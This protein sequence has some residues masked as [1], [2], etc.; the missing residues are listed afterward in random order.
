MQSERLHLR[1][2][3]RQFQQLNIITDKEN[4]FRLTLDAETPIQI[5]MLPG[6][7]NVKSLATHLQ[8]AGLD[9]RPILYPTVP[10]GGE[11]LRIVFHAF[12]TMDE[13]KRLAGL[14]EGYHLSPHNR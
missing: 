7:S 3:I 6:N 5:L 11:R 14:L 1:E 12:N 13:V 2:L 4:S 9:V 8:S 10:K